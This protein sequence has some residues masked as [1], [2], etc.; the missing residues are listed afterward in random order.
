MLL[1]AVG[2]Q[3][4]KASKSQ[5]L[6]S[7][8]PQGLMMLKTGGEPASLDE[9]KFK[10]SELSSSPISEQSKKFPQHKYLL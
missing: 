3:S 9:A 5:N 4:D 10:P 7:V 6:K 8:K 1:R 2:I